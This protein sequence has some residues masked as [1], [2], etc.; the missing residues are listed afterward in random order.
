[1]D[2][3]LISLK[4]TLLRHSSKGLRI[5]GWVIGG[6]F[7]AAT[8]SAAVFASGAEVRGDV[9]ALLFAAWT[10]GAMVGP[11]LLSGAGVLRPDSFALLP[12]ERRALAR[13]LLLSVFV[14]I[15]AGFVLL[16]FLAASVHAALLSPATL[17][18]VIVGAP[19]IDEEELSWIGS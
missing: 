13:G 12:I 10:I 7:V 17:I 14:S 3:I 18:V 1:M 5:F 11:V 2:R 19:D 4:F 15:A 16:A 6:L 9:L 8:W